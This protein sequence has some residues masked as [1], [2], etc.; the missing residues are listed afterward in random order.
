M[1]SF[2]SKYYSVELPFLSSNITDAVS[3]E[4]PGGFNKVVA[5]AQPT[6]A[7]SSLQPNSTEDFLCGDIYIIAWISHNRRKN[8]ELLLRGSKVSEKQVTRFQ[9]IIS[10][11]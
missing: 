10:L 2:I 7:V 11:S 1:F 3:E 9:L 4:L 6:K 8:R 5:T